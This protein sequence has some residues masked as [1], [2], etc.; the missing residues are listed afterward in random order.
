MLGLAWVDVGLGAAASLG[1]GVMLW[2]FL[3]RGV[4]LTKT[5]DESRLDTWVLQNASSV[6]AL[7]SSATSLGI[8]G[9]NP[10]SDNDNGQV[11]LMLDDETDEIRRTDMGLDWPGIVIGP[12]DTMSA[13]IGVNSAL[14]VG[15]R[16]AGWTGIAER[17]T[18]TIHGT[19]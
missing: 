12:G 8:H 11:S 14:V 16:R 7:I 10:L 3:P 4:V 19:V 13:H 6:P 18:L 5:R 17:R 1:I 2:M 15:Y 9:E